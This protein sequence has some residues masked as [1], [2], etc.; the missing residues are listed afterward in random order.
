MSQETQATRNLYGIDQEKTTQTLARAASW[1]DDWSSAGVRFVQVYS[2][3][4]TTMRIGMLTVIWW[5]I[6]RITPVQR[7]NP[8]PRC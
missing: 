3:G 2:G 7:I 5:R 4:A 6:I 8:S 1:R